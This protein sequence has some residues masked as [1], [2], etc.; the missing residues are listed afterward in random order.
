L[1]QVIEIVTHWVYIG[2]R[3]FKDFGKIIAFERFE[4]SKVVWYGL[5]EFVQP[6]AKEF[7]VRAGN[8]VFSQPQKVV[9]IVEDMPLRSMMFF[10]VE[11]V[12]KTP[13]L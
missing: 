8:R 5:W 2:F 12:Y 9:K 10:V 7:R 6:R 13:D 3:V 11:F 4:L 1:Q